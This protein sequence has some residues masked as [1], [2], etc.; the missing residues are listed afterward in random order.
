MRHLI[1]NLVVGILGGG[2]LVAGVGLIA[3]GYPTWPLGIALA[4]AGVIVLWELIR[5]VDRDYPN[6]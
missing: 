1:A 4:V 3:D 2:C 5:T 6:E